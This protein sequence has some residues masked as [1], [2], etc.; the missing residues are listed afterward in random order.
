M[1]PATHSFLINFIF[2]NYLCK[3]VEISTPHHASLWQ[4]ALEKVFASYNPVVK[5]KAIH[6]P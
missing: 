6:H 5:A 4:Q 2:F 1:K 3:Y